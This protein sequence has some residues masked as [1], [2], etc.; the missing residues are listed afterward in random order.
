MR[1]DPIGKPMHSHSAT[2]HSPG[3]LESQAKQRQLL[4]ALILVGGF[5]VVEALVGRAS[6]SFALVAEA[7]HLVADCLALGL[8]LAASWI[9]RPEP[10][11]GWLGSQKLTV[12]PKPPVETWAALVNGLGLM[13]LG[14]WIGAEAVMHLRQPPSEI[15]DRAMLWTAL[16]GV[17]VNGINVALLHR[18]SGHD[19]NLKGAFLHVLADMLS[20]IGVIGAAIAVG[21]GHFLWADGAISLAIALLI[22]LSALPLVWASGRALQLAK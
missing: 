4:A 13:G 5:A 22:L 7:G 18:G 16:A 12:A 11:W 2:C 17:G 6:H 3:Q 8:A 10:T 20:S 15:A 21:Q 19:L 14:L 1:G 9:A